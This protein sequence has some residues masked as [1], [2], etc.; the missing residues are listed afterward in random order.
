MWGSICPLSIWSFLLLYSFQLQKFEGPNMLWACWVILVFLRST[1][2]TW[3]TQSL[4]CT[5]D[6][7]AGM[8][9]GISVYSH[10]RRTFVESAHNLT[11]EK[12]QGRCKSRHKTVAWPCGDRVQSCITHSRHHKMACLASVDALF[13]PVKKKKCSK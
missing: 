6:A 7:S 10:G 4:A 3:T 12:S 1:K 13:L 8:L 5:R 9:W 2:L 11:P